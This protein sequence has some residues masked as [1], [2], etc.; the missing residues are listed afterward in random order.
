MDNKKTGWIIIVL[1]VIAAGLMKS[2]L[3]TKK[4]DVS[5]I[6]LEKFPYV[7]GEYKGVDLGYPDW[8][9]EALKAEEFILRSYEDNNGNK[10]KLYLAYFTS[11]KGTS[12]HNPDVCYPAQ[13]WRI[14]NKGKV[15][16]DIDGKKY[17]LAKRYFIKGAETQ[18]I[19]FWYQAGD[20]VYSDKLRH[21]LMVIKNAVL[22]NDMQASIVRVSPISPMSDEEALKKEKELSRLIIPMLGDYLP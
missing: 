10:L 19:L 17:N 4:P 2:G 11:R 21:Q 15:T 1:L 16:I 5:R 13:G 18:T 14:E 6:S 9:E 22:K 8:L 20:K 3:L 7:I 12:T